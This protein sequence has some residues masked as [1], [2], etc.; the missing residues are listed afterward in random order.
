MAYYGYDY[1]H[2]QLEEALN[3]NSN[4]DRFT[5]QTMDAPIEMMQD[6]YDDDVGVFLAVT[7]VNGWENMVI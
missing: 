3:D 4:E 5:Q 6:Q 7:K 1:Y 2:A